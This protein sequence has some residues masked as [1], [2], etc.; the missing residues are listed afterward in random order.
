[1]SFRRPLAEV[2]DFAVTAQPRLVHAIG[3]RLA[4]RIL[5]TRRGLTKIAVAKNS[6]DDTVR[7]AGI[8]AFLATS[9]AL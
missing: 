4:L 2:F 3:G 5:R 8:Y 1:M 7:G 9:M 6:A